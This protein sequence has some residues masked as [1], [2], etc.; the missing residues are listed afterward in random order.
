METQKRGR[1]AEYAY[2][3]TKGLLVEGSLQPGERVRVEEV[4]AQLNTSRQPVMDAFK[5]L[6]SEGFIEIIPQ[7]GCRVVT[8]NREE[9]ED[10]FLIL[11]GIESTAAEVAATRRTPEEITDLRVILSDH[12]ALR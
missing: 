11:T 7:V 3:Y 4:V 12:A 9:I 6:A 10:F 2:E 8:P 1:L 5:R